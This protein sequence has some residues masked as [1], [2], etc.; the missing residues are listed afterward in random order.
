MDFTV[1]G[2]NVNLASRI[3][4]ICPPN[5]CFVSEATFQRLES[6]EGWQDFGLHRLRGI[7]DPVRI[8]GRTSDGENH[9]RK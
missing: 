1:L 9:S 8:F 6:Q 4:E 5:H 3:E 7:T 2:S